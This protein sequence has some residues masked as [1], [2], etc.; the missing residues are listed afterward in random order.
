MQVQESYGKVSCWSWKL[1]WVNHTC[2]I[3]CKHANNQ[4]YIV[5]W[6]S[7]PMPWYYTISFYHIFQLIRHRFC[8]SIHWIALSYCI[9]LLDSAKIS[10]QISLH[11][12][13]TKKAFFK[14]LTNFQCKRWEIKCQLTVVTVITRILLIMSS[15][16]ERLPYVIHTITRANHHMSNFPLMDCNLIDFVVV[17]RYF[18]IGDKQSRLSF[19]THKS[20]KYLN[21]MT[22]LTY[23]LGF[24]I[25]TLL[26]IADIEMEHGRYMKIMCVT[27]V[28]QQSKCPSTT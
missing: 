28:P 16:E 26:L 21:S 15:I 3:S 8:F 5:W 19:I 13:S 27:R 18:W 24:C 25:S 7:G 10:L 11:L 2:A 20:G 6:L 17:L 22:S 14:F 9:E 12:T 23:S 4:V 1:S